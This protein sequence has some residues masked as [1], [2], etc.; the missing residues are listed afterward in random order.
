[1][2]SPQSRLALSGI[3]MG[4]RVPAQGGWHSPTPLSQHK[5]R[6]VRYGLLSGKHTSASPLD[7]CTFNTCYLL[8]RE[9]WH[10]YIEDSLYRRDPEEDHPE[11]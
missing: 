6:Q 2:A 3:P 10:C 1:V 4:S 9:R 8:Y 11:L 5:V 7:I